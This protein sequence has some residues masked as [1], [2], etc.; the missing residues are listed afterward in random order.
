MV[1]SSAP[2]P[3][4]LLAS[5]A[6]MIVAIAKK[7]KA[8][9]DR[10]SL[11]DIVAEVR[12][13][14]LQAA[15]RFDPSLGNTFG[16]YAW[17]AGWNSGAA[18]CRLEQ[19]R[20]LHVPTNHPAFRPE[21]TPVFED[22]LTKDVDAEDRTELPLDFWQRVTRVLT[23]RERA[24]ILMV[25]RDGLTQAEAA[26]KIGVSRARGGQIVQAAIQRLQKCESLKACLEAA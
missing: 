16:T 25:Y 15:K 12:V 24:V 17:P 7:L 1:A 22:S 20:G 9:N 3:E 13:G 26:R 19:A 4:E 21:M 18:Y 6:A 11:A 23:P 14:F 10:A 5:N 8:T 2:T